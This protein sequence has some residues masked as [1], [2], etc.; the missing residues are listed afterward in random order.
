MPS[1]SAHGQRTRF[2]PPI[3]FGPDEWDLLI[4]LPARVMIAATSAEPDSDERTVAEGLAGIDAIAAGTISD[5]DLVRAVVG[6]I[7]AEQDPDP[8]SAEQFLDRHAGITEVLVNCRAASAALGRR[9][10]PADAN[11]Y[12]QWI[13]SIAARVCGAS[14]SG[15]IFGL[16]GATV[17]TGEKT[18]LDDLYRALNA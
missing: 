6:A 9:A 17:S 3:A 15:G 12:R 5:S 7:Y 14:R 1:Q 2:A 18:F 11:A 16:G 10:D 13:T 4:R 8:P